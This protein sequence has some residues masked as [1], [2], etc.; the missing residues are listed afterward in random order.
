[1]GGGGVR[2]HRAGGPGPG[3]RRGAGGGSQA[4]EGE[5]DPLVDVGMR[6]LTM[7]PLLLMAGQFFWG[8][9]DIFALDQRRGY[10]VPVQTT[11]R[12]VTYY[13]ED[14]QDFNAQYPLRSRRRSDLERK[15]D[16]KKEEGLRNACQG[17]YGQAVLRI[18]YGHK[19][20]HV[21]KQLP[22]VH[23]Q[24]LRKKWGDTHKYDYLDWYFDETA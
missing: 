18:R 10:T 12:K 16:E 5:R 17:E 2:F 9:A 22:L 14:L 13:V 8:G 3:M 24:E 11:A 4:P 23:C 15:I 6:L 20:D 1:M 21:K 19:R 7:L